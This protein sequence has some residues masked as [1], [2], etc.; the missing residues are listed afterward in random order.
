MDLHA[1]LSSQPV[2]GLL[3]G[4]WTDDGR[5]GGAVLSVSSAEMV[6]EASAQL[7]LPN[8]A[9]GRDG[10]SSTCATG[11]SQLAGLGFADLISCGMDP[12]DTDRALAALGSRGLVCV[13]R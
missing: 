1:H 13:G 3:G 12:A 8:A 5:E 10:E 2:H 9:Y 6:R 11:T 4:S 7:Q